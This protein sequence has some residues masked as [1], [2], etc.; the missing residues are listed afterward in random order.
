MRRGT[1]LLALG[2]CAAGVGVT[3]ADD[4]DFDHSYRRG[5]AAESARQQRQ[6]LYFSRNGQSGTATVPAADEADPREAE[7]RGTRRPPEAYGEPLPQRYTRSRGD[8]PLPSAA[9]APG[10]SGPRRPPVEQVPGIRNYH[11]ELFGDAGAARR[12]VEQPVQVTAPY[13]PPPE[14]GS[15]LRQA[16]HESL[17]GLSPER[18]GRL[19]PPVEDLDIDLGSRPIVHAEYERPHGAPEQQ[20]IHPVAGE[21][22]RSR[23]IVRPA[24]RTESPHGAPPVTPTFPADAGFSPDRSRTER[25]LTERLL[26][27]RSPQQGSASERSSPP[28]VQ[29][30]R[31]TQAPPIASTN[32]SHGAHSNDSRSPQLTVEWLPR[33]AINV[34]Q[35]CACELVVRNSGQ[36]EARDV[37]VEAAFPDSVRLTDANP[38]PGENKSQLAWTFPAIAPGQSQSIHLRLVPTRRGELDAEARVRFSG[39]AKG[40][41]VV[42][43]PLL[44][45]AVTGPKEVMVGDPASQVIVVSN[46]GTGVA[47][48]VIIEAHIPAGL[49]HPRGERLAMDIGAL[50]PGESRQVRL[51]LA[52]VAGGQQIVQVSARAGAN[53]REATEASVDVIAPKLLVAVDGPG[54][55]FMGRVAAYK[56][57]VKNSGEAA[58]NNVRLV[59]KVPAGFEFLSASHGGKYEREDGGIHWFVGRMQPNEEIVLTA[60]FTATKQGDFEHQVLLTSEHGGRTEAKLATRVEGSAALVLDIADLNDPVEIGAETGYEIRVR[61]DGSKAATNVGLSCE[62]SPGVELIRAEGP[63]DRIAESGLVVFKSL[64]SLPAGQTAVFRVIVRG[65]TEGNHRFRARL[66]SD[67]IQ[68]PL[69][70]EEL[71]RFY[72]E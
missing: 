47:D 25:S 72:A 70:F 68:E 60:Q 50:S 5:E 22:P 55:R 61:N 71:T 49:E 28:T 14:S 18:S 11:E 39:V 29:A 57:A 69:I 7:A 15:R 32:G 59:H 41:F 40:S 1:W 23:A 45:L 12:P 4:G 66:A 42:E 13:E 21:A 37:V 67:S 33:S 8:E 52:A 30:N 31:P 62:L 26:P 17:P 63:S 65:V 46:P 58:S 36:A 51:A 44:K 6:I 16:S 24:P 64:E 3:V 2:L 48:N 38:L 20:A 54:L 27:E 43:E 10:A 34:G 9:A 35:E 56:L 19:L 53:L